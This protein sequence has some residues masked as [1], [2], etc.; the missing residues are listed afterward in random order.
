MKYILVPLLQIPFLYVC[1]EGVSSL[2]P[3]KPGWQ[4]IVI[5]YALLNLYDLGQYISTK[6]KVKPEDI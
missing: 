4:I 2:L 1:I 6:D 3:N 5:A